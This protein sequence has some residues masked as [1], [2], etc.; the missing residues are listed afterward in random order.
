MADEVER[1]YLQPIETGKN[2]DELIKWK[3]SEKGA[4]LSGPIDSLGPILVDLKK[5]PG[6]EY[7]DIP[8][9]F[10]DWAEAGASEPYQLQGVNV[11]GQIRQ[12]RWYEYIEDK[13][14]FPLGVLFDYFLSPAFNIAGYYLYGRNSNEDD[15]DKF[16]DYLNNRYPIDPKLR[17]EAALARYGYHEPHISEFEERTKDLQLKLLESQCEKTVAEGGLAR[18]KQMYENRRRV[19]LN[20]EIK[21]MKEDSRRFKDFLKSSV[22]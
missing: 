17:M 1:V 5:V 20:E 13:Q 12:K 9:S 19:L 21:G 4:T 7:V 16:I 14:D 11:K 2:A 8:E 10:D 3:M 15:A 22:A 18:A 6:H